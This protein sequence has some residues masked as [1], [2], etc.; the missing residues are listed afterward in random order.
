[1]KEHF[2]LAYKMNYNKSHF[3][4][5]R[6]MSNSIL[7]KTKYGYRGFYENKSWQ[8]SNYLSKLRERG[9]QWWDA[10][11]VA[12][13]DRARGSGEAAPQTGRRA[14]LEGQQWL[15]ASRAPYG[16]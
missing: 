15:D 5:K 12:G 10:T 3:G 6:V 14:R 16:W 1:V 9:E 11:V 2:E 7:A 8:L 13:R 4:G